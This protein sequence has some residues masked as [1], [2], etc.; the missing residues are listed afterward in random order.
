MT[1]DS[2]LSFDTPEESRRSVLKK[3]AL[4]AVGAAAAFGA[5]VA[6][7]EGDG[8]DAAVQKSQKALLFTDSVRPGAGAP[9]GGRP[10]PAGRLPARAPDRDEPV[11]FK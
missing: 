4:A 10:R 1:D 2:V 8:G 6:A 5:G 9:T 11:L 7:A 3:S